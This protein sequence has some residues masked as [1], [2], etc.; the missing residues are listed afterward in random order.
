MSVKANHFAAAISAP[1]PTHNYWVEIPEMPEWMPQLIQSTGFP[2]ETV[3]DVKIT[4][5]GGEEIHY[6]STPTNPHTWNIK[7]PES[8]RAVVY[9]QFEKLLPGWNQRT[10]VMVAKKWN[11]IEIYLRDLE[12]RKIMGKRLHGAW[13]QKFGDQNLQSTGITTPLMWDFTF[14]FSW[15]EDI[16]PEEIEKS[17]SEK[18]SDERLEVD[19]T[20]YGTGDQTG[21]I[22]QQNVFKVTSES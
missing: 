21:P 22:N 13:L 4:A 8:D 14:V 11:K 16:K 18:T 5:V 10:G 17:E 20:Q 9:S 3:S 15:L 1:M 19:I 12:D 7:V 6:P 2:Q